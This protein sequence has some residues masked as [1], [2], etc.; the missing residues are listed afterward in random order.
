MYHFTCSI[1]SSKHKDSLFKVFIYFRQREGREKERKRHIGMREIPLLVAS[2]PPPARDLAMCPD[3]ESKWRHFG[4]QNNARSTEPHQ[5]GHFVCLSVC[6][7]TDR[8]CLSFI[9]TNS[10][11]GHQPHA[12]GSTRVIP[13][14]L[15]SRQ[16]TEVS[17]LETSGREG[18]WVAL[19]A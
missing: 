19:G 5:S 11:G 10:T 4:L 9:C 6:L 14:L 1:Q 17:T 15:S 8:S 18:S 7:L 12:D 16:Q 13:V 2:R 3:W